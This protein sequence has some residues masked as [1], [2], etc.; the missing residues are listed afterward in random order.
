MELNV[1]HPAFQKQR[2]AVRTAGFL[3]GPGVLLNGVPVKRAR[4]KYAVKDDGG[5]DVVV[6]LKAKLADPVPDVKINDQ[7]I[8]LARPLAW[9]EY[10]WIGLPVLLFFAGGLIGGSIGG[11]ATYSSSRILRTNRST[12]SKY[13][14]TGLMSV[15]ALIAYLIA[16]T[17]LQIAIARMKK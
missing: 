6:A 13:V 14:L 10:L 4:G 9:Y 7:K 11:F 8:E 12:A 5:R 2:L 16:A 3:R 1:P 15:G 17:A